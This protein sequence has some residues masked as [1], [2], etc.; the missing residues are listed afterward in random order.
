MV[1]ATWITVVIPEL[2]HAPTRKIA[3]ELYL[4]DTMDPSLR[5]R[6]RGCCGW[7]FEDGYDVPSSVLFRR[8]RFL[9]CLVIGSPLMNEAFTRE[10]WHDSVVLHQASD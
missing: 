1:T 4:L 3:E 9:Q 7:V 5:E 6:I 10:L 2:V 8:E